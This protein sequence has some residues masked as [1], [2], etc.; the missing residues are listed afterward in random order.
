M[1]RTVFVETA[2]NYKTENDS[3]CRTYRR[4]VAS[5]NQGFSRRFEGK[6]ARLPRH[7][8]DGHLPSGGLAQES[9]LEKAMLGGRTTVPEIVRTNEKAVN[10]SRRP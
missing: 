4:A 3:L 1:L 7:F 6:N 2:G 8:A 9:E 10:G 5:E